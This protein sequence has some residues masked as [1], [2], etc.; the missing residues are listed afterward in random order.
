MEGSL[1]WDYK[2]RHSEVN[3]KFP[4]EP[5][6]CCTHAVISPEVL[7]FSFPPATMLQYYGTRQYCCFFSN[8]HRIKINSSFLIIPGSSL[9]L[10]GQQEKIQYIYVHIYTYFMTVNFP[11][12]NCL[13]LT[14]WTE[15]AIFCL[16][17]IALFSYRSQV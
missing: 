3:A 13:K 7:S 16:L 12:I 4:A 8:A 10:Y 5:S 1:G 2:S 9:F 15:I 11:S 17:Y 6:S 14:K